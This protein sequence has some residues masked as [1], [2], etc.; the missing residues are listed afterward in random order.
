MFE[1]AIHSSGAYQVALHRLMSLVDFERIGG[2]AAPTLKLD[3]GRMEELVRLMGRPQDAAPV[4]HVAGTKGKGSV[5]SLVESVLRAASLRTTLF[6]SP[7]LHTFRERL[8]LDGEPITEELFAS[9]AER[10]WWAVEAMRGGP[11]GTPT[12]FEMLTAMVF[13]LASTERVDVQVLEVGLGGRLDST[14]VADGRVAVI[15]SLSLDHTA[16][17]GNSLEAI[18]SEKAG[19]IKPGAQVVLSPQ[20]SAAAGVVEEVARHRGADLVRLGRDVTWQAAGSDLS[21]QALRLR[22]PLAEYDL[23]LPL[24]GAHQRENAAAAVAAAELLYPTIRRAAVEQ[25]VRQ[26]R[27]PGRFQVLTQ[28]PFVVIVD[29]AHNPHSLSR[30][31]EAVAEHV[32]P[33]RTLLVFGCS[34]DKDLDG[35]VREAA[36]MAPVVFTCRSRHPRA[37]PP[38]RLAVAFNDLSIEAH[39][40]DDVASALASAQ[41]EAEVGDLVLVTGSL[42]VVAEALE[43]WWGIEPELYSELDG[44]PRAGIVRL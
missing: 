3:L 40:R 41:E 24:L 6:T 26:V 25:G 14:N 39:A 32:M 43:A 18:A 29:G 13:D 31:R 30:L 28:E 20:R 23:W 4:V 16:I 15:T 5:A 22:T 11:V 36:P 35:M 7:H 37:V 19:I 27:W 21:G 17:L 44:A 1:L 38:E 42:F 33:K 10:S 9:L 2:L 34:S 8:R 12:T